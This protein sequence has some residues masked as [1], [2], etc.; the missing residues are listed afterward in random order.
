MSIKV[1]ISG[2]GRI[3]RVVFRAAFE[4]EKDI[5]ICGINVRNADKDYMVYM[6]KYD[7][8]FG[9][10]KGTLE[11]YEEGICVNGK[12]IPVY[13]ESD[14]ENIPWS[15]CGAEYIVEA[16][17]AYVTTEKA[18]KHI[19]AGAKKIVITAPAKDDVTP[20]YVMG[21][22]HKE[23]TS[24]INVVSNASCT[25]NC[26][27]PLAK[28]IEDNYGIEQGLMSTIHAATAKQKVVDARSLKD[29]RTGR[30]TFGNI[31]P[32]STGAAKAV[33]LVIP[34]LKG[35]LTGISYRVPVADV[36]VIDLNIM[37]NKPTTYEDMC[38]KIKEASQT[39]LKDILE[40]VDDEV[41]SSDFIGDY[42]TSIFDA[43]EGIM[44][45]E[46]FFKLIAFYDN[47][48]GYSSKILMLIKHM[49]SIDRK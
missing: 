8:I 40:Y 10:F 38:N 34:S 24:D 23:Y 21:V 15:E 39:Y 12:K 42:H 13:S 4:Q 45:N 22:N 47:E 46:R 19:K 16:T 14:A 18:L 44:L 5:E 7:T 27:A 1:G 31:I 2:F 11:T 20:T 43:R 48:W 30:S 29:W 33:G 36:S 35:K 41:V 28:V 17:G 26:L 6:L 3:G 9:R 37:L 32:S 49:Y 25:T